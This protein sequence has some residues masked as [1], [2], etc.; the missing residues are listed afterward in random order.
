M[1]WI[2]HVHASRLC[3]GL[4]IH[5]LCVVQTCRLT[6]TARLLAPTCQAGR[7]DPAPLRIG[8]IV[9]RHESN[10]LLI[11][12]RDV[13]ELGQIDQREVA[14]IED[15]NWGSSGGRRP[16]SA[17][18]RRQLRAGRG[19]GEA[20][21]Q[22]GQQWGTWS[23]VAGAGEESSSAKLLRCGQWQDAWPNATSAG[24]SAAEKPGA[25]GALRTERQ[26]ACI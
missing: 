19:S 16:R 10:G 21:G 9:V 5:V 12:E 8:A 3:K 11:H 13:V 1:E 15:G 14:R 18:E 2:R 4:G 24:G 22:Q 7:V 17:G 25:T 20:T 26:L 23:M 6:R